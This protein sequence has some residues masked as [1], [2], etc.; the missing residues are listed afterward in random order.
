MQN[1]FGCIMV[2]ICHHLSEDAGTSEIS[3]KLLASK[4]LFP[5]PICFSL[6]SMAPCLK[7]DKIIIEL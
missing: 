5:S 4:C 6:Y 3:K 2:W 7:L 1:L